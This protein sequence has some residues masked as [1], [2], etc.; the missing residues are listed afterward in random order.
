MVDVRSNS[1]V[2]GGLAIRRR[3]DLEVCPTRIGG[4][5]LMSVKDP[6]ALR[7][8][9]F[10]V[11]EYFILDRLDGR[12]SLSDVQAEFETEFSPRRLRARQLHEFVGRLHREGLV[13][14]EGLGRGDELS[15][16]ADANRRQRRWSML[17]NPL[18]I[19]FPGWNPDPLLT[20]LYPKCRFLMSPV[21]VMLGVMLMAAAVML[22]VTHFDVWR[23]RL[24]EL[25]TLLHPQVLPWIL[26]AFAA[27]KIL[28]EFGH[29][30]CCKH[31]GGR[32]HEMGVLLLVFT[33]CL[34]VNVSDSWMFPNRWHRAAVAAAGIFVDCLVAAIC[35]FLWWFSAPGLLHSI[36]LYF[37]LIGS[38]SSV[39]LNGNPL[40][41]YDGYFVLSDAL[42]YPNLWQQSR[43]LV[44][45][46]LRRFFL[47]LSA[48]HQDRGPT[49]NRLVLAVYAT[50]SMAYRWVV[51][52]SILWFCHALL[53]P[54]GLQVLA[55]LLS[56]T[57]VGSMVITAAVGLVR[58][59]THPIIRHQVKWLRFALTSSLTIGLFA[60]IAFLPLPHRV[61]APAVIQPREAQ[62]VY[63]NV[64]GIL[65]Q[66]AS[67]GDAVAAGDRLAELRNDDLAMRLAELDGQR[68]RL[69]VQIQSIQRRQAENRGTD[70]TS[71]QAQLP[72]LKQALAVVEDRLS[73]LRAEV[74]RLTIRSPVAG[75]VIPPPL[76]P[77][78]GD[79]AQL[80]AWSGRPLDPE[81]RGAYLERGTLLC[82]IG[83]PRE[84]ECL[85]VVSAADVRFLS[86]GQTADVQI[87]QRAGSPI[88]GRV[89]ALAKID[90]A[91]IPVELGK[92]GR[93]PAGRAAGQSATYG[94]ELYRVE[95]SVD[96]ADSILPGAAA[97]VRIHADRRSLGTRLL[98]YLR[99]TFR[100]TFSSSRFGGD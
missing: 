46:F 33:P 68:R 4:R 32:P 19:R 63:V 22:V 54:Y 98:S 76:A 55:Q 49:R 18:A 70:A 37:M 34:F 29:G 57:V 35:T 95:I 64:P 47:G 45:G 61:K 99:R 72:T 14:A 59:L 2:Q 87:D 66:A 92:T 24:P 3:G 89:K 90:E 27:S 56:V 9:H 28:H 67:A 62:R 8:Y 42:G 96:A 17:T 82:L 93:L 26:L 38:V 41:R 86:V 78:A 69:S 13:V 44:H 40:L 51:V 81:N 1:V 94:T 79:P 73:R 48:T 31:F 15:R 30:L 7:Y 77:A 84:V 97:T 71:A 52:I 83:E 60:V 65:E 91:D 88:S 53:K 39:L 25:H 100:V 20:W 43:E 74:Q 5:T 75:T 85:A 6:V 36:C 80:D 58:L 21:A 23:S 12:R 16:R 50:A 11:E 10:P